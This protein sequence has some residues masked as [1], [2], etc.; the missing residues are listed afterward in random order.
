MTIYY[1][2]E[3]FRYRVWTDEMA[4]YGQFCL[5]TYDEFAGFREGG[6]RLGINFVDKTDSD[7]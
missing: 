2:I 1:I 3:S 6:T 5:F 4:Q 7:N